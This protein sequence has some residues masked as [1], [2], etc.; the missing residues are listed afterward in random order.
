MSTEPR[1]EPP[2]ERLLRASPR[3]ARTGAARCGLLLLAGAVLIGCVPRMA[4]QISALCERGSV[5]H[6]VTIHVDSVTALASPSLHQ[7]VGRSA[8]LTL[9]MHNEMGGAACADQRGSGSWLGEL[10]AGLETAT[11]PERRLDWHVQG[12]EVWIN[13]NPHTFDNNLAI[14][15]PLRGGAGSWSLSTLV[16]PVAEGRA[17]PPDGAR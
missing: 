3:W 7:I 12:E 4:P 8:T 9:I 14:V 1:S 2:E 6:Q 13:L 11:D 15:L 5:R 10:P 17:V 16:G